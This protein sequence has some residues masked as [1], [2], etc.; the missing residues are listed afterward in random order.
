MTNTVYIE[1]AFEVQPLQPASDILMAE[2]GA[3]GFESFVEEPQGILAYIQQKDWSEQ[4]LKE[5]EILRNTNFSI[6]FQYKEIEQEN[7][8]ANWES[9]FNPIQVG[10]TCVVRAPF[11]EK[12]NVPF[13]I[14]IE[15]KMS[16]GTGHHETTYMML[17][18]ILELDCEG[19]SVLDMGC[20]TGVLAIL[21]A[22]KGATNV[23]AIDI[24][25]WCFEN[26]LE[27][28]ARNNCNQ[29]QVK[30]GDA[31]L[32]G[33]NKYDVIIANIN[34]NILLADIP[35]YANCLSP[36]GLLLLSGFYKE[37]IAIVSEKC[38]SAALKFEKNFEKNNWVAVK[39]VL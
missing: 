33:N 2:L 18:H 8:N 9:N 3:I 10:D 25:P 24:D 20:G 16:F 39:Y 37:D 19:K 17:E 5:V 22:M 7:W 34:R 35:S 30:Q 11:H 1:Y 14:V 21:S 27:N 12:P 36:K 38:G 23:D 15:P 31:D 4:M 29:I 13:D 26:S 6:T 28:V 32:L